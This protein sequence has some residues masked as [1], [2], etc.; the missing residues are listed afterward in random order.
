VG[1]AGG[2]RRTSANFCSSGDTDDGAVPSPVSL[3]DCV[4]IG[5]GHAGV[6]CTKGLIDQGLRPTVI[7]VGYDGVADRLPVFA[8]LAQHEPEDW[9]EELKEA[10]RGYFPIN[11]R[12]VPLK[13]VYGSFFP[14]AINDSDLSVTLEGAETVQ[15]LA[16]GGLSNTWGSSI[17][18]YRQQD[19]GGWPIRIADLEPHYRSVLSFMPITGEH[20]DLEAM[21]PL[22]SDAAYPMP[23]TVQI[24]ALVS[25]LR[26]HRGELEQAGLVFGASRLAVVADPEDPEHCRHCG[27]CMHGCPF[28]SIYNTTSTLQTLAQ[29]GAIDYRSGIYVDHLREIDDLVDVDYHFRGDTQRGGKLQA[30]RVFVACGA[31][32]STRLILQSLTAERSAHILDS[33]TFLAPMLTRRHSP[34]STESQGNTLAQLFLEVL[35]D[36]VASHGIH[37]QIYGYSDIMLKALLSRSPIRR[38][39]AERLLQPVIGRLVAVQGFLHSDDSPGLRLEL[40]ASGVRLVGDEAPKPRARVRALMRKLGHLHRELGARP[41]AG[42]TQVGPPAK[43]FHYGGSLPMREHPRGLESDV[44]GRPCGASRIHVVDSSVFPSIAGT[45]IAFTAMANA[46]R[47]ATEVGHLH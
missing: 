38:T 9:P 46:H 44:L 30:K 47:I 23:H 45:T 36:E 35:D 10:A 31:V 15:S 3:L 4:V 7:D 14:Y 24:E 26:R 34:V 41:V 8:E 32:S 42:L 17:L 43:S 19:I 37:L 28:G 18:P 29:Q 25:H 16:R 13:P 27:L 1:L 21:F 11:L 12:G 2:P 6:A 20:D 40:T 22:F 33:Q 39:T 5:S